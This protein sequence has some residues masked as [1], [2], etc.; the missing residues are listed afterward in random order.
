[1]GSGTELE[2]GG[3]EKL[4]LD[5]ARAADHIG[6]EDC[7]LSLWLLSLSEKTIRRRI[8]N[9]GVTCCDLLFK[10]QPFPH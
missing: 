10:G 3:G 5:V 4:G 2:R 9:R 1:M 6:P 8:L 7:L